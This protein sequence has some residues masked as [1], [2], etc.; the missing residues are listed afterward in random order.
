MLEFADDAATANWGSGW[1][2]PSFDQFKELYDYRFTTTEWTT[3]NGVGGR[4][5]TSKKNGKSIFLPAAGV[6]VDTSHRQVGIYGFYWSR[7]LDTSA[8]SWGKGAYFYS[9]SDNT[10]DFYRSHGQS[11]RPVRVK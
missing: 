4:K 11:V 3:V 8:P 6:H 5:I 10:M 7:S 9:L 2:M 1:Q